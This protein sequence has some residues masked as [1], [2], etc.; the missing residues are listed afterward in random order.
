MTY[1]WQDAPERLLWN[2]SLKAMRRDYLA[3]VVPDYVTRPLTHQ[4]LL[5]QTNFA[6]LEAEIEAA[7]YKLSNGLATSRQQF[8]ILLQQAA[9]TYV[10]FNPGTNQD[11]AAWLLGFLQYGPLQ[12]PGAHLLAQRSQQIYLT[13]LHNAYHFARQ[14]V[15]DE[16]DLQGL[17]YDAHGFGMDTEEGQQLDLIAQ[18]LATQP[19]ADVIRAAAQEAYKA[20]HDPWQAL[21]DLSDDALTN[22]LARP[23]AHA[24]TGLGRLG[25]LADLPEA[26]SY[27]AS[28]LLDRSTCD[29]CE[30]NDGHEYDTLA[31]AKLD[32]PAGGYVHCRGGDRCRGTLVAVWAPETLN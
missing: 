19:M 21:S 12:V 2:E 10:G 3:G 7:T 22:T 5:A 15:E 25:A 18:R 16:A 9:T 4:E 23:A 27:Y 30:D 8:I 29:H 11:L 14:R 20:P 17:D 28:E 1:R 26:Q 13:E 6:E 24:A 32:Y 31:E